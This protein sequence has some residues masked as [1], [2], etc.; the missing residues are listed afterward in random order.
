MTNCV[1]SLLG[2]N[3]NENFEVLEAT[4]GDQYAMA[5]IFISGNPRDA[6][7]W[8]KRDEY[9]KIFAQWLH[10]SNKSRTLV[11]KIIDKERKQMIGYSIHEWKCDVG[12]MCEHERD[13]TQGESHWSKQTHQ[14]QSP[15]KRA[16]TPTSS[17]G[18]PYIFQDSLPRQRP[19]STCCAKKQR[20]N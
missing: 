16:L 19:W 7:S 18:Q 6:I 13:A 4:K 11:L 3:N 8:D 12:S 15:H 20:D 1:K 17:S 9:A 2:G 14:I 5:E 10:D